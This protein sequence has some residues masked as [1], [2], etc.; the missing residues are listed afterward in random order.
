M[1]FQI[2]FADRFAIE[3]IPKPVSECQF[4]ADVAFLIDASN[5]VREDYLSELQF[6]KLVAARLV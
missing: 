6:V 5:S 2:L 4:V 1:Y 3:N